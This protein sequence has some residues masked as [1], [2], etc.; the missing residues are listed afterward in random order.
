MKKLLFNL[1]L[2]TV[3]F[4]IFWMTG[5]FKSQAQDSVLER[6]MHATG[7]TPPVT[8]EQQARAVGATDYLNMSILHSMESVV[9]AIQDVTEAH[10]NLSE[11][12][13]ENLRL[14]VA[15]VDRIKDN[16]W[17]G[18]VRLYNQFESRYNAVKKLMADYDELSDSL[19]LPL[20]LRDWDKQNQ[21]HNSLE[22]V[23]KPLEGSFFNTLEPY[24]E[25]LTE[26]QEE[27]EEEKT[28]VREVFM[29]G[30][31]RGVC[32]YSIQ[33]KIISATKPSC[34][35]NL[36]FSEVECDLSGLDAFSKGEFS[37]GNGEMWS[38]FDVA[39]Q[40]LSDGSCPSA[41]DCATDGS[42]MTMKLQE[43]IRGEEIFQ[44]A[45]NRLRSRQGSQGVQ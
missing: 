24:R 10:M 30:L 27:V 22:G 44:R 34:E 9:Q 15:N 29:S 35:N 39:C 13:L 5:I 4:S 26:I 20:S 2:F 43:M 42:V 32:G 31:E 12:D 18:G 41:L 37:D 23:I 14:Q 28:Q 16:R 3:S 25:D 6:Q 7:I 40:A 1:F 8:A 19:K 38:Q 17:S 11:E 21:I 36:C 33:P 45:V